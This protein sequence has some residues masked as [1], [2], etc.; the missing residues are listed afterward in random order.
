MLGC[1]RQHLEFPIWYLKQRGFIERLESGYLAIT[2]D[3]VDKLGKDDLSLP[4]NRLIEERSASDLG[5]PTLIE[6]RQA[7]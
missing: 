1:P 3:G 2:A 6:E 4:A 7:S 5:G